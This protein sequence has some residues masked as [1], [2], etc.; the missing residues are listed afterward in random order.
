MYRG[1]FTHLLLVTDKWNI[2]G[3]GKKSVSFSFFHNKFHMDCPGINPVPPQSEAGVKPPVQWHDLA[4]VQPVYIKGSCVCFITLLTSP[5]CCVSRFLARGPRFE[6]G[7]MY[8]HTAG[9]ETAARIYKKN[10]THAHTHKTNR[11]LS[12]SKLRYWNCW[13]KIPVALHKGLYLID[14]L[15]H[16]AVETKLYRLGC[17]GQDSG[18]WYFVMLKRETSVFPNQLLPVHHIARRCVLE[19][20]NNHSRDNHT[21]YS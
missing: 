15:A 2:G 11:Y 10:E 21:S 12:R 6:C 16:N 13:L 3:L 18:G 7:L 8:F 1:N 5:S 9:C 17:G 20:S 4:C 19:D 14:D